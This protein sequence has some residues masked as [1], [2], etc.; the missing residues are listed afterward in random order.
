MKFLTKLRNVDDC[1]NMSRKQLENIFLVSCAPKPFVG[2]KKPI[3]PSRSKKR[4]LLDETEKIEIR[5]IDR[6][7]YCKPK[8]ITNAFNNNYTNYKNAFND[9]YTKYKNASN[10]DYTK[11]KSD[12]H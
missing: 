5:K 12:G 10:D 2:P 1:K 7:K 4:T 9:N 8:N 3:P 11:Y 6:P